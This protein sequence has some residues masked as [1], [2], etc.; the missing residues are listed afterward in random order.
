MYRVDYKRQVIAVDF[1]NKPR[2]AKKTRLE[3]QSFDQ[4]I[5][6]LYFELSPLYES[7]VVDITGAEVIIT[8]KLSYE[9]DGEQ[10]ESVFIDKNGG[11]VINP[12]TIKY[13]L[14]DMFRGIDGDL[15][16]N[17]SLV[18]PI[19]VQ[20]TKQQHDVADF[21]FTIR[22]S[23]LDS[24]LSKLPDFVYSDMDSI[25][26]GVVSDLAEKFTGSMHI[27]DDGHLIMEVNSD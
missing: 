10:K 4:F 24:E 17:L 15:D 7:D 21:I 6:P 13:S 12:N 19:D 9:Q 27:N 25:I 11:S 5:M 3:F 16:M 18:M 1:T 14:P 23:A 22:L 8:L 2:K 26:N 20:G